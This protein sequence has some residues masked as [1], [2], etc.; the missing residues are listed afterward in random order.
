MR[1]A[2]FAAAVTAASFAAA[3]LSAA[4]WKLDKTHASVT[5]SV[6]HF[7]FALVQGRFN[8]FDA[9]IDFDP[10][11]IEAAKVAFTIQAASADTGLEKRDAHLTAADFLDVENHPE[12]TF[13]S[14]SVEMTGDNTAAVTGDVTIKGVTNEEIFEVTLRKIGPSPF[15]PDQTIAGL[16]VEGEIDRT[17]YGVSY[18]APALGATLPVRIDLEM[19]PE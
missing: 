17:K 5:F 16:M 9:E 12:I 2:L 18:G 14:K 15:N 7:G 8:E 4:P 13:V 19:S 11:N 1:T 3:P 10:E 6:D